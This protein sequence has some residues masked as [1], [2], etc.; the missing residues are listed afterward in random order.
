MPTVLGINKW[1]CSIWLTL[2]IWQKCGNKRNQCVCAPV[3]LRLNIDWNTICIWSL[4]HHLQS[5]ITSKFHYGNYFSYFLSNKFAHTLSFCHSF[6]L[7]AGSKILVKDPRPAL[8]T[9]SPKLSGKYFQVFIVL[10]NI[11]VEKINRIDLWD[12]TAWLRINKV[13]KREYFFFFKREV[14]LTK[15]SL[16]IYP[17]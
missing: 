3:I 4:K 8:G 2:K 13:F 11:S 14:S 1:L 7:T 5:C 12:C 16:L 10:N 6:F 15:I 9:P 17:Y